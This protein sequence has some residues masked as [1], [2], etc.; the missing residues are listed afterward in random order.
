MLTKGWLQPEEESTEGLSQ[1]QFTLLH[2]VP[3]KIDLQH[4]F[5]RSL[6][7]M[8]DPQLLTK[9]RLDVFISYRRSTGSQLAR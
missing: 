4:S 9:N 7:S 2:F 1:L 8:R 3:G 6:D 5:A